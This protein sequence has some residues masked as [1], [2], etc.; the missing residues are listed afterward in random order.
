MFNK[1]KT[2]IEKNAR[3]YLCDDRVKLN[4]TRTSDPPLAIEVGGI[5]S[6]SFFFVLSNFLSSYCNCKKETDHSNV[7]RAYARAYLCVW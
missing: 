2:K 1:H 4:G 5:R 6:T 7:L 3:V